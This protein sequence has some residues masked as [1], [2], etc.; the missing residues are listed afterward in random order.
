[1]DYSSQTGQTSYNGQS[2]PLTVINEDYEL[3]DLTLDDTQLVNM[4]VRDLDK[5]VS[6]WNK[7]PWKLKET[8]DKNIAYYLGD[9][10]DSSQLPTQH[11]I[12]YIDNRLFASVR[13]IVAYVFGQPAKPDITPSKGDDKYIRIANQLEMGLYQ[14]AVNHDVNAKFRL[15]GKNLVIRKRGCIKLRFDKD[16]GAFGDVITENIDPSDIVIDRFAK[17]GQDPNRIYQRLSCTIEELCAKYPEKQQEIYNVYGIKRGVYTQLSRM[18]TYYECWFSYWDKMKK[19]QGVCWFIPNSECILGKMENPNWIYKGSE[20]QQKIANLTDEPIKP[21]IWFNYI[22]TGRSFIDETCLFDQALPQQDLLNKRGRQIWENADYANPRVLVNGS[23]MDQEDANKFIN[24]H[25]KTIG[26]LNKMDPEANINNAVTTISAEMLPQYVVT[27]LYD[28]RN[29]IDTMMGTPSVFR[30]EQPQNQSK[31]LGQ[32]LLMKQQA[33]A[34]QDDIVLIVSEAWAKYYKYLTQM[35]KV[36]CSDDYWIMTRGN[37]GEYM[38][39][40]L[41][42]DTIDTNV[43]V[44]VQ[45]DSTLPLDKEGR[46]QVALALAKGGLIDPLTLFRD[47]GLPDAEERAE[48][49]QKFQLDKIGYTESVEQ[50]LYN[51][52]AEADITL[53]INKKEPEERD[54]YN[55]KYLNYYNGVIAS[56]RFQKLP[57]D[58]QSRLVEF[59]H[60]IADKA[61][62]SEGFASAMLNPAGMSPGITPAQPI[63]QVRVNA[64]ANPGTAE[65]LLGIQPQP[66]PGAMPAQPGMETA[67]QVPI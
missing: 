13:A 27:T 1:M 2:D 61:A 26:L 9:Q 22:N 16:A 6:H 43:K 45:T 5:D 67:P 50:Q 35:M 25:P 47:L 41:N 29:E 34:L 55:E 31:T 58:V 14:H 44:G 40:M 42:S 49:L 4:V 63:P 66:M 8:D 48:R 60:I 33:G 23:L 59:L 3:F 46:K 28:S 32:D 54:N 65:Q 53:L 17:N 18:V 57:M 7:A 20:K 38:S 24:K 30:G 56:N 62:T 11:S 51:D 10:V 37:S 19:Q 39:I 52:E 21:Y 12:P 64:D 36:Y 15:A